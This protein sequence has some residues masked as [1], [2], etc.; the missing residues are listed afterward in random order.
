MKSYLFLL[1]LSLFIISCDNTTPDNDPCSS[2]TCSNHGECADDNGKPWCVCESSY[3]SDGENCIFKCLENSHVNDTND[4]CDCNE[5]YESQDGRCLA[6]NSC[7]TL[8]C[9]DNENCELI[10]GTPTCIEMPLT[11]EEVTCGEEQHCEIVDSYAKCLCSGNYLVDGKDCIFDCTDTPNSHVNSNNNGCD[12]DSNY[13]LKD[14]RC[15]INPTCE[16]FVCGE[17]QFCQLSNNTP[18]CFCE[19]NYHFVGDVCMPDPSCDDISCATNSHCELVDNETECVCNEDYHIYEGNCELIPDCSSISCDEGQV[20]QIVDNLAVCG[21]AP[22]GCS[23]YQT[24]FD[25]NLTGTDMLRELHNIISANYYSLG[26]TGAKEEMFGYIDNKDNQVLGVY[27]GKYYTIPEGT[28]PNQNTFNCEHT[29]PQS[30]F[31]RGEPMRSD[32]HHLFPTFSTVNSSR[33]HHPFGEVDNPEKS[34]GTCDV[35]SSDYYCSYLADSIFEP[36]DQHKGDVARAM[37]YF[38][39]RYGNMGSSEYPKFLDAANQKVTFLQWNLDDPVDTKEIERNEA[40]FLLQHNRN[41]FVD[42]PV[43]LERINSNTDFPATF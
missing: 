6:S 26:Y 36:A 42:C 9:R 11:C 18:A 20:C 31:G 1:F 24:V 4:G 37:F 2:V 22:S 30:Q 15:V 40:I 25:E 38:A 10:D 34:F 5:G 41:P 32:L 3:K 14:D 21:D 8:R 39:V 12:C 17:H 29:W 7:E 28:M 23:Y 43:L 35:N 19:D 33:S 13:H 16:N 27:T